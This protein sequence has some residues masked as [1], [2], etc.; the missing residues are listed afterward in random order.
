MLALCDLLSSDEG[1]QR[2]LGVQ[3]APNLP[4][5][6]EAIGLALVEVEGVQ[7]S[8]ATAGGN[9]DDLHLAQRLRALVE[10]WQS[11]HQP[12]VNACRQVALP[13]SVTEGVRDSLKQLGLQ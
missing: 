7:S 8:S 13:H 10:L 6:L 3:A 1:L 2:V 5:T 9:D 4:L 12:L 11:R